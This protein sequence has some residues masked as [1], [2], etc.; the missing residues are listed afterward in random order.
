MSKSTKDL[1]KKEPEKKSKKP[2][3]ISTTSKRNITSI[4]PEQSG[5]KKLKISLNKSTPSKKP[6]ESKPNETDLG[7]FKFNMTAI[8]TFKQ[9]ST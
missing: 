2:V 1:K 5:T 8:L 4:S 6:T 3:P 7:I 9:G